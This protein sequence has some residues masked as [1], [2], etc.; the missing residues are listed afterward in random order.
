M[1]RSIRIIE[2]PKPKPSF[3]QQLE[4]RARALADRS[5]HEASRTAPTTG[6]ER[7]I[8]LTLDHLNRVRELHDDE[9]HRLHQW[10]GTVNNELL[11]IE[12]R[13]PVYVDLHTLH[14]QILRSRLF[15]IDDERRQ[16]NLRESKEV[17]G[18][19]DRLLQLLNAQAQLT[20]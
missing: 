9:R 7:E 11:Q 10:E 15:K 12:P 20:P 1:T 4:E 17:Q 14:R 2:P 18:L 6:I 19:Q 5:N 3:G 8:A 16:L 13:G